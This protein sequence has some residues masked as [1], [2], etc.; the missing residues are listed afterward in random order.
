MMNSPSQAE[1]PQEFHR[2]LVL[3]LLST[4]ASTGCSH[5]AP[6]VAQPEAV[7]T[8]V[9]QPVVALHGYELAKDLEHADHE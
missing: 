8:V 9:A 1:L 4:L 2:L 7:Q 3:A 5:S 6:V